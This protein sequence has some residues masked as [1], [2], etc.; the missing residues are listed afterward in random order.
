MLFRSAKIF[1][2]GANKIGDLSS[3]IGQLGQLNLI[4]PAD[5]LKLASTALKD[6]ATILQGQI[7]PFSS[8]ITQLSSN[9]AKIPQNISLKAEGSIPV[10]GTII[11]EIVGGNNNGNTDT[12]QI[13]KSVINTISLAI[14]KATAGALNI[15]SSLS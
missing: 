15:S 1:S 4:G 13:E 14:N 12:A 8:A 2:E 7:G 6:S 3:A 11:V 9:L 5:S 10:N